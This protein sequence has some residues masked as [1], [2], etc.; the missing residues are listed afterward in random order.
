MLSPPCTK[1]RICVC[2]VLK[3]TAAICLSWGSGTDVDED[4]FDELDI[5]D[6]LDKA[7][8]KIGF[9]ARIDKGDGKAGATSFFLYPSGNCRAFFADGSGTDSGSLLR[10]FKILELARGFRGSARDTPPARACSMSFSRIWLSVRGAVG[11]EVVEWLWVAAV[12][13][14]DA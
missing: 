8:L 14:V 6:E 13:P 4:N 7:A 9:A 12:D 10:L 2:S 5:C 3:N 1:F 11:T